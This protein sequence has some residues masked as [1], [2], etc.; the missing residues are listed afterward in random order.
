MDDRARPAAGGLA[1]WLDPVWCYVRN[2]AAADALGAAAPRHGY[3][4]LSNV[5]NTLKDLGGVL[6]HGLLLPL[7]MT[8][9]LAAVATVVSR[10]MHGWGRGIAPAPSRSPAFRPSRPA[11][12]H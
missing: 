9:G 12:E 8:L 2:P 6:V 3:R 5:L 11:P 7:W 4:R 10:Q 1:A